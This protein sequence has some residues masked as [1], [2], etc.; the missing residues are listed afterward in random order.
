[1]THVYEWTCFFTVK[2]F[3]LECAKE[4]IEEKLA[5]GPGCVSDWGLELTLPQVDG[6]FLYCFG[7]D[8]CSDYQPNYSMSMSLNR[9]E[10]CKC[11]NCEVTQILLDLI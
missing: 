9:I 6:S 3:R 11:D 1:M 8:V 5:D 7:L 2:A 10:S 4:Y